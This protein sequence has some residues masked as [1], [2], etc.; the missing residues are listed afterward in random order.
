[1]ISALIYRRLCL[2][3]NHMVPN[4]FFFILVPIFVFLLISLPLK[5]IIRFSLAGIPYDLWVFPGLIFIISS[6]TL[7]P[8]IFREFFE[9]RINNKVL[10]NIS[11]SPYSKNKIILS[12]LIVACLETSVMILMSALLYMFLITASFNISSII[13]FIFCF[14]LHCFLI[15]NLYITFT[16]SIDNLLT[17]FYIFFILMIIVLF[18]S[19]FLIEFSFFP[20][21]FESI[22]KWAPISIPFQ[23]YLKFS[24]TNIIDYLS[25]FSMILL[26]YLWII[27]N[28]QIL[29]SKLRQ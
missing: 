22:L 5:N 20:P 21:G 28:G 17:I 6:F 23:I 18:G 29:K 1:M 8:V 7:Y 25:I 11:L 4:L 24:S 2:W 12:N 19:G 26:I 13:F 3:K 27:V 15:G 9:L 10:M 16:L 14:I